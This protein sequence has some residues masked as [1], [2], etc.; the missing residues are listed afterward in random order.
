MALN[1]LE[2]EVL[3]IGEPP[4]E[5]NIENSHFIQ[6][7]NECKVLYPDYLI[8]KTQSPKTFFG[9][10]RLQFKPYLKNLYLEIDGKPVPRLKNDPN[11]WEVVCKGNVTE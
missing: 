7:F 5:Q 10:V 4:T 3:N 2:K 8:V 6:L 1:I 9:F 11:G